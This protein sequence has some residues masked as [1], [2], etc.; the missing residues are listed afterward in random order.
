MNKG[1]VVEEGK[2][3]DELY[4]CIY[5][6]ILGNHETLME[7]NGV[8]YGLVEAQNLRM[9]EANQDPFEEDEKSGIMSPS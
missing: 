7:T 6:Q 5:Q 2:W 9:K 3:K 4:S 1:V 8:Y